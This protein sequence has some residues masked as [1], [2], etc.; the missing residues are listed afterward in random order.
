MVRHVAQHEPDAHAVIIHRGRIM[1]HGVRQDPLAGANRRTKQQPRESD[2]A[3]LHPRRE[4]APRN[5]EEQLTLARIHHVH[6]MQQTSGQVAAS[7]VD[8]LGV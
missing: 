4:D 3:R 7:F 6:V 2:F 5:R 1:N 8:E